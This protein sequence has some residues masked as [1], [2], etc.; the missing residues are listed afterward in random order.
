VNELTST[1]DYETWL[2]KQDAREAEFAASLGMP[3]DEWW[4]LGEC[5]AIAGDDTELTVDL[6]TVPVLQS[7]AAEEAGRPA[8][9]HD[10]AYWQRRFSDAYRRQAEDHAAAA[11]LTRPAPPRPG[12]A[13]TRPRTPRKSPRRGGTKTTQDPGDDGGDPDPVVDLVQRRVDELTDPASWPMSGALRARLGQ[14]LGGAR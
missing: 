4:Y 8:E 2:A 14:L 10:P 11:T 3:L 13:A 1:P 5:A 12:R 6:A 7:I 9:E